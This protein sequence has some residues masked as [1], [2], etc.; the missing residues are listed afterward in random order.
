[1]QQ[2]PDLLFKIKYIGSQ[3]NLP[4]Y[5]PSY[6]FNAEFL[7]EFNNIMMK[8]KKD[9]NVKMF[10]HWNCMQFYPLMETLTEMENDTNQNLYD[11]KERKIIFEFCYGLDQ[12]Y[13]ELIKR[14]ASVKKPKYFCNVM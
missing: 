14:Q 10:Q 7:I 4:L 9:C 13:N 8:N 3:I 5:S 6:F 1:M 2:Y 11:E 12:I